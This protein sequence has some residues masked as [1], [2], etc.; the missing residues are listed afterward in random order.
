MP[1]A[2]TWQPARGSHPE[3]PRLAARHINA[4]PFPRT[5]PHAHRTP[6]LAHPVLQTVQVYVPQQRPKLLVRST[7][8]RQPQLAAAAALPPPPP[9]PRPPPPPP[10]SC[11][12]CPT[13]VASCPNDP[14][15]AAASSGALDA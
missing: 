5:R 8:R 9:P 1:A 11:C 13:P 2:H 3:R 7:H 12:V 15:P 4:Q 10:P 14:G 6:R